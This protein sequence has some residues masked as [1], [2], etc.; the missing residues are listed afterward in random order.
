MT[1]FFI[2][3]IFES[4]SNLK[5]FICLKFKKSSS[6][7]LRIIAPCSKSGKTVLEITK[8]T[9]TFI[10]FELSQ[11]F[12]IYRYYKLIQNRRN[13]Y[14]KKDFIE[15]TLQFFISSRFIRNWQQF[16]HKQISSGPSPQCCLY[17]Q[18]FQNSNCLTVCWVVWPSK[19]VLSVFHFLP[20]V[21]HILYT[22]GQRSK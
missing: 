18:V 9:I 19:Q 5:D 10:R 16:F 3:P 22:V 12:T 14:C 7:A 4:K 13:Y 8:K 20:F 15:I 11:V 2:L 6:Y 21:I 1:S 17:F